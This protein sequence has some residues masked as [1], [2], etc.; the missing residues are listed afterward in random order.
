MSVR[1]DFKAG[2]RKTI[3]ALAPQYAVT[4]ATN[5]TM[6]LDHGGLPVRGKDLHQSVRSCMARLDRLLLGPRWTKKENQRTHG[7]L[8]PEHLSSNT[9]LHGVLRVDPSQIDRF[10]NALVD[11]FDPRTGEIVKALP[12]WKDVVPSGSS[13]ICRL[14]NGSGWSTYITKETIDQDGLIAF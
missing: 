10:E 11:A 7:L 2:I 6:S 13:C 5:R 14:S 9:H 3:D 1:E 4:L 8:L 12:L